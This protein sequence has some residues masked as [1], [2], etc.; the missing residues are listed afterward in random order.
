[1]AEVEDLHER[2]GEWDLGRIMQLQMDAQNLM[3]K[4]DLKWRQR[5]KEAWLVHG[6]KNSKYFHACAS[7]RRRKN[8]ISSILDSKGD[9]RETQAGVEEAFVEHFRDIL[10]SSGPRGMEECLSHVPLKVT[11]EM[12]CKL[13]GEVSGDEV[14]NAV[15]QM[16]PMKSPG[17]D[18]FPAAFYQDY[19]H[20]V[21]EEVVKS[22]RNFFCNSLMDLDVNY[23]HIALVQKKIIPREWLI[24]DQSAYAMWCIKS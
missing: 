5:A 6:D 20:L 21:G 15:F 12:N 2:D 1:L 3:E 19:W 8:L 9:R 17:P 4:V 11:A 16:A 14:R 23:T 10:S 22:V 24:L 18:G 13:L 7:Q